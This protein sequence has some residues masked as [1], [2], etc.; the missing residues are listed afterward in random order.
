MAKTRSRVVAAAEGS[1]LVRAGVAEAAA[2]KPKEASNLLTELP[3]EEAAANPVE[4]DI[5]PIEDNDN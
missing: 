4:G 1:L 3:F 2:P 5:L